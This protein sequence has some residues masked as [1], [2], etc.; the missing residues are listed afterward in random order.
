MSAFVFKPVVAYDKDFP[1]V[2]DRRPW[3]RPTAFLIKDAEAPLGWRVD[4]SGR[5]PSRL[6]LVAKL[7]AA[8]D[9]WRARHYPGAS[10]VTRRLFE[11]WFEDDHDIAGFPAPFRY[12]FCQREAIEALAYVFEIACNRD[13][14]ELIDTYGEV[15]AKDLF[16]QSI[17]YQTTMDGRRQLR[18]FFPERNAVGVQD[19]PPE[20]LRRYAFKLA[21]GAG[22]TWVMAM[23]AVWSRFHRKLVPGS[24]L[25]TNFLI[26]APNIIVYQRLER[27]F[28]SNRIFHTLPLIPPE[29]RGTWSQ[30]VILRGES[31]EPGPSGNLVLINIQQL[32]ESRRPETTPLNAVEALLGRRPA[33]NLASYERS[34]L[35]RLRDLPDLVVMND[36]AHHVHREDLK[37]NQSL[38]SLHEAL[39]NGLALWLDFSATPKDQR[40]SYYPWTRATIRWPR[41]SRIGSSRRP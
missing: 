37:W 8:V 26:V 29:W 1:E 12:Y 32:Y 9:D 24:D 10:Q 34:L 19:L 6:L 3:E 27:D 13:A 2:P 21:T 18:R 20:D 5:R 15:F 7:R 11:Y 38:L 31:S 16:E 22:K 39:P 36:E 40:G 23:A 30:Q 4:A 35:E 14:K 28:G 41:R 17:E 25:S 33:L